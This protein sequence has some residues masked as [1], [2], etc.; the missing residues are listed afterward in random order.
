MH[1]FF[2][3][4]GRRQQRSASIVHSNYC[5]I[6]ADQSTVQWIIPHSHSPRTRRCS[7]QIRTLQIQS[8]RLQNIRRIH[9][10]RP[11]GLR[12]PISCP[13]SRHI[14]RTAHL[15]RGDHHQQSLR[16]GTQSRCPRSSKHP[17]R[18]SGSTNRWRN[19]KYVSRSLLHPSG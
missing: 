18:S 4:Q 6:D 7:H 10:K 11:S 15:R 3:L 16:I 13:S 5:P 17:A 8:P 9:G 14:R 12:R 19:G 2:R 1:I